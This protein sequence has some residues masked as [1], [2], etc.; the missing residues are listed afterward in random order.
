[1]DSRLH[2]NDG[3]YKICGMKKQF[4]VYILASKPY[5][6]LYTGMTSNLPQRI[7]KHRDGLYDGFTKKYGIKKLVWYEAHDSAEA[8]IIREKQIKKWDRSWKIALIEK[9]NPAWRDMFEEICG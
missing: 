5:G 6:T 2:G 8:A 4:F 9:G 7:A 3:A 1:M